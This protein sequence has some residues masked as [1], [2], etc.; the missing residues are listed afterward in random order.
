MFTVRI[1]WADGYD[2]STYEQTFAFD[3]AHPAPAKVQDFCLRKARRHHRLL[4]MENF[5]LLV[6]A[7][8]PDEAAW[9]AMGEAARVEYSKTCRLASCEGDE[10]FVNLPHR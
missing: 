7:V 3:E 6:L 8:C 5:Q 2:P 4:G 9:Q 1:L 10:Y